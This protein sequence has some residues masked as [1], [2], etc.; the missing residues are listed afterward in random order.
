MQ[1]FLWKKTWKVG[2]PNVDPE[3]SVVFIFMFSGNSESFLQEEEDRNQI[4]CRWS[5]DWYRQIDRENICYNYQGDLS[6][7][8]VVWNGWARMRGVGRVRG[9]SKKE[10]AETKSSAGDPM[11]ESRQ[12]DQTFVT[13]I[14]ETYPDHR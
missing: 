9:E 6:K 12:I 2:T 10:Q 8:Q 3:Y 7:S 14:K 13:P 5:G 1:I 11:T 4:I